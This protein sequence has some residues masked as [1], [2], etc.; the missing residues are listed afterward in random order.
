MLRSTLGTGAC[1][2]VAQVR[3]IYEGPDRG[4][5]LDFIEH[6]ESAKA[7]ITGGRDTVASLF[8]AP[9]YRAA[10]RLRFSFV[11]GA[12]R[13]LLAQQK[14]MWG[15]KVLDCAGAFFPA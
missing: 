8:C 6:A 5:Q 14:K 2:G 1:F 13:F 3:H 9:M 4:F 11:P 7:L 15:A 10:G 12:A